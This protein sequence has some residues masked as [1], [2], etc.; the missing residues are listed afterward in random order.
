MHG[1]L[2]RARI[3]GFPARVG[4]RGATQGADHTSA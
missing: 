2:A 3:A 1:D 4:A